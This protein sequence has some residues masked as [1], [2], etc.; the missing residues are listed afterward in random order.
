MARRRRRPPSQ[1]S[2]RSLSAFPE[3]IYLQVQVVSRARLRSPASCSTRDHRR[4]SP[5]RG[6]SIRRRA[7]SSTSQAPGP[8]F[9][10]LPDRDSCRDPPTSSVEEQWIVE[11]ERHDVPGTERCLRIRQRHDGLAA[12]VEVKMALV[13]EMFDPFDDCR[14]VTVA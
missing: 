1:A 2:S 11:A 14:Y 6:W 5:G 9:P 12:K 3:A 10:W 8:T 4:R 7:R 13:T